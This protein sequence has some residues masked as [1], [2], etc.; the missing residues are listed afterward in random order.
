MTR[1]LVTGGAGFVGSSIA[2]ALKQ[3][4]T[5]CEV[6]AFDNLHRAGSELNVPR[7]EEG[8][9][10]FTNGDVRNR[11]DLAAVGD[12]DFVIECAAEPSVLAGSGGSPEYVLDTNLQGAI[13]CAELCRQQNAGI[14]FLS[15]S[16][17][18]PFD[19][20]CEVCYAGG[21]TRFLLDEVQDVAGVSSKGISEDLDVRGL[22]SFYGAA[23]LSAEML[24]QE[25]Q[26]AFGIPVVIDRCGVIAGPGQFGKIDQGIITF[27]LVSH[28]KQRPLRYIGFGGTGKQVRDVLHIDD[29]LDLVMQQVRSPELYS[30]KPY[31]VGGG[32]GASVSLMELSELCAG[33]TGNALEIGRDA[34]TRYADIPIYITDNTRITGLSGWSAKRGV[35]QTVAETLEWLKQA[36]EELVS[37]L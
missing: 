36:P 35:E 19:R 33:L 32:I 17:V 6:I 20:L 12:V 28:M 21:E 26:H 13:N 4:F 2:F 18:Y 24:L 25:Y 37:I 1:Y 16:R 29:L 31:N 7:L 27:W 11:D 15:T 14:L 8:G 30:G 23:K 34:E 5:D 9:V 22:K 10:S 3:S